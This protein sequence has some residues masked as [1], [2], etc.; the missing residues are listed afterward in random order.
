M[1]TKNKIL[2]SFLPSIIYFVFYVFPYGFEVLE[3]S[4]DRYGGGTKIYLGEHL[5]T[6]FSLLCIPL[7]VSLIDSASL[8]EP[9]KKFW[10][11]QSYQNNKDD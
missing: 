5:K 1:I 9:L 7:L 10:H 3:I 8:K 6:L 2:L 11:G 4:D